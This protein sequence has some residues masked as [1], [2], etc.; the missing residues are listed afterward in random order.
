MTLGYS[1]RMMAE[2]AT[3]QKLGTL[4]RMHEAA[5][6]EWQG[7]PEEILYDRMKTVWTGTDERGEIVWNTV[8]LDFA[9]YWGFTPR[10]C[11]PYW[12]QTKG[13]IESG[14][15]YIR[16]N[17]LCGLQGCEP[18]SLTDFNAQLREW[19][20]T[21]ANQRV[22]GTTR[23]QVLLRWDGDQFS[24]QPVNGRLPYPYVDDELRK[25]ARDA[26]VS[27]QG[28]RYSVPWRYAG[29]PVWVRQREADIEVLFGAER[30][31][32]HAQ[33][34]RRHQVIT[35]RDHHEGIPLGAASCSGK[36]LIHIQ[37]SAPVVERR[38]LET[39]ESLAAEGVQ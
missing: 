14:V 3:D 23:E 20:A 35:R 31:A 6:E 34:E 30:I 38:S 39:Y 10:L 5:F 19:V 13:K 33:A 22:H 28:S 36:T 1:R 11:R 27:W 24:L 15:K 26:Y 16:R 17:F 32:V 8:F 7:V 4:L 25:V 9:R 18:G 29:N 37:Q 2:A 12:A 21:V